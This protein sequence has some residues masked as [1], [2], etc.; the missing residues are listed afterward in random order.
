[1]SKASLVAGRHSRLGPRALA[2]PPARH[3]L[4]QG[5]RKTSLVSP[6]LQQLLRWQCVARAPPGSPPALC[7]LRR[8]ALLPGDRGLLPCGQPREP[9]IA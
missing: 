1:M 9:E 5:P 3:L 6:C 7:L 4:L 8:L 2:S